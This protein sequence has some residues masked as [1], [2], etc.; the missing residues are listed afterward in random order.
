[1]ADTLGG[2]ERPV[3]DDPLAGCREVVVEVVEKRSCAMTASLSAC[4]LRWKSAAR[5]R[6]TCWY[7]VAGGIGRTRRRAAMP[8]HA[9]DG[10]C[11]WE[12]ESR[13]AATTDAIETV[14]CVI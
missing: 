5:S 13:E 9:A 2:H 4:V 14:T 11:E 6:E 10:A 3:R 1:L 12:R 7:D 8:R